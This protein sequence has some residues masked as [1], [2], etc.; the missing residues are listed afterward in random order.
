VNWSIRKAKE[1][2]LERLV[3]FRCV[4]VNQLQA[5][6]NSYDLGVCLGALYI[7][8]EAGWRVLTEGVRPSGFLA[9]SDIFCK[10]SP[11]PKEVMDVF[12]EEEDD[13]HTLDS[14][15]QWYSE[16]GMNIVH[17]EECSRKSWLEYYDLAAEMHDKIAEENASDDGILEEVA[18]ER[19]EEQLIRKYGQEFVGYMTFIMR[20]SKLNQVFGA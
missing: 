7:F 5:K 9:V 10:K 20:R 14:L 13:P 19:S 11:A 2:D 1:E 3:D 12:F 16:R 17:E 18:K 6:P 8:R 4:D 15:H